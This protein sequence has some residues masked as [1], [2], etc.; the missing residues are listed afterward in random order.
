MS[1][2]LRS[3]TERRCVLRCAGGDGQGACRL[4]GRSAAAPRRQPGRVAGGRCRFGALGGGPQRPGMRAERLG[5]ARLAPQG[6]CTAA[7]LAGRCCADA[8]CTQPAAALSQLH[9]ALQYVQQ[10]PEGTYLLRR[11]AG[12]AAVEC[13]RALQAAQGDGIEGVLDLAAS[14]RDAGATD[15]EN[16]DFVPIRWQARL[17]AA[18]RFRQAVS[19]ARG[20][21][22]GGTSGCPANP[23]HAPS[24]RTAWLAAAPR[25]A[26]AVDAGRRH[27][28]G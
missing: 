8:C 26:A 10:L 3:R 5:D 1:R 12:S 28:C 24:G 4:V 17:A 6:M 27:A 20:P 9:E 23:V 25:R 11:S 22:V 16:L 14:R 7:R 19:H 21:H 2:G 13:L 15:A 18:P